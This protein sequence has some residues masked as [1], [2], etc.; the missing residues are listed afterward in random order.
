MLPAGGMAEAVVTGAGA[1]AEEVAGPRAAE[2]VAAWPNAVAAPVAA[3]ITNAPVI[4]R[5]I[6][7]NPLTGSPLLS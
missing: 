5:R 6:D 7:Q 1:A 3:A 4:R 2:D